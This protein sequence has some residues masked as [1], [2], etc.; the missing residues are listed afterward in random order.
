MRPRAGVDPT[1]ENV[2]TVLALEQ[3]AQRR[4]SLGARISDRVTKITG[5][6]FF[7]LVNLGVIGGWM[8][9]N[10]GEGRFDP[11]PFSLLTLLLSVEAIVLAIFVLMSENQQSRQAEA[12]AQLDLQIDVLA[13]QELT[14]ALAMLRALCAHFKL[15]VDVPDERLRAWLQSTKIDR[16]VDEI[17]QAQA[18]APKQA[19]SES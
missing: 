5:T 18:V 6:V 15:K 9:W 12:R 8:L 1:E 10:R 4:R 14:A 7:A 11:F 2:R 16:V 17:E 3:R 13:E 19:P